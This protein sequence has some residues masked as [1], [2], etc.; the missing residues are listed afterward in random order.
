M[1]MLKVCGEMYD[2]FGPIMEDCELFVCPTTTTT[3]VKADF[4]YLTDSIEINGRSVDSELS[5][6]LCHQFNMLGRCPV[7]SVPSGMAENGVPTGVQLVART[8]DD[9]TVF[10]AG[11]ALEALRPR[12]RDDSTR[13]PL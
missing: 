6:A 1:S 10:R 5:I 8:Y 13:P 3:R 11:A 9:E 4:N 12:F 2:R 7:L